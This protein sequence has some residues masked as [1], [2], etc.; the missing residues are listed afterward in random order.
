MQPEEK[1]PDNQKD[2]DPE[3][4]YSTH[5]YDED[6]FQSYLVSYDEGP[7]CDVLDEVERDMQAGDFEQAGEVGDNA[8]ICGK[9]NQNIQCHRLTNVSGI[10]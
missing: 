6:Q 8:H 3:I 2:Q 7:L 10:Q 9:P 1:S 4:D 5:Q